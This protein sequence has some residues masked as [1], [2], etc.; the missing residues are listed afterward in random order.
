MHLPH[1]EQ[2]ATVD[3]GKKFKKLEPVKFDIFAW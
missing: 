2:A 3:K 1:T